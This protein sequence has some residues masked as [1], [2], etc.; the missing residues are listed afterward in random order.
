MLAK[1][2]RNRFLHESVTD[3]NDPVTMANS[4]IGAFKAELRPPHS[5]ASTFL[6]LDPIPLKQELELDTDSHV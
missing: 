3:D 5:L 6:G 2:W 4:S 1:G